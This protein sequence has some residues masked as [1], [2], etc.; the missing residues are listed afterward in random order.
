MTVPHTFAN[1]AGPIPLQFLDDN[2]AATSSGG[3][4]ASVDSVA[5]LRLLDTELTY[6]QTSSYTAN[7]SGGGG[8]YVFVST[9][10]TSP[11]NGCTI[12]VG[13]GGKRWYLL[14][15]GGVVDARQGG[16]RCDFSTDDTARFIATYIAVAA[17][18]RTLEIPGFVRITSTVTVSVGI[19]WSFTGGVNV[20]TRNP[21]SGIRKDISCVGPAIVFS[22]NDAR[23]YGGGVLCDVGNTGDAIAVW[24]NSFAWYNS[25]IVSFAGQDGIR[26][27]KDIGPS[28]A[29]SFFIESPI[30]YNC[31]RHG[32]NIDDKPGGASDANAGL[33][34]RPQVYSCTNDGIRFGNA[35]LGNTVVCPT[36]EF[37]GVGVRFDTAA[38]QNVIVGGDIEANTVN[39]VEAIPFANALNGVTVQGIPKFTL[40]QTTVFQPTLIGLTT[41]GTATYSK[42]LGS[43]TQSFGGFFFSIHIVYT[44]HTGTGQLAFNLPPLTGTSIDGR[45]PAGLPEVFTVQVNTETL[46]VAAGAQ[47]V[48]LVR[49]SS[50]PPQ[51]QLYTQNAGVLATASFAGAGTAGTILVSG[52]CPIVGVST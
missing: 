21:E 34:S 1:L 8:T 50:S 30:V 15:P 49:A 46:S 42:R 7:V 14:S 12:I 16:V 41:A 40:G 51:L 23:L 4:A 17:A 9:D 43:Y 48:G 24:G 37:N 44:G 39:V 22:G 35:G 52:Y 6:A 18:G 47:V 3:L 29:N 31:G 36:L 32:I 33:I 13:L 27:G 11:D 28:N 25:P 5:S 26:I 38:T 2:F 10:V 19:A 20:I 45:M